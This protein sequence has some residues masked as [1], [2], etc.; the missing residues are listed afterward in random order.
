MTADAPTASAT[1][2]D[3]GAPSR[4][5]VDWKRIR[6]EVRRLQVRIAKATQE[7]RWGKVKVLQRLL[8][9]SYSGKMLAVK[10]VTENRGKN[11]PG[12][13]GEIW[14]TPAAKS[15]GVESLRR[16]GYQPMPLRRVYIPKSNGKKRPLG[17]PTMKDRAMQALWK[18]ALE[19]VAETTADPDSYGFR[20]ARSTA[21]AIGQCFNLLAQAN[22]VEWIL[23]GDIRGCFD[24][25]SHEWLL[26]NIPM[27]WEILRKWLKAGFID[28]NTFFAT[29]AGT[30]QGGIISPILANMTLD[31]LEETLRARFGRGRSGRSSH[32]V[33]VVRYADDFIV[34]GASKEILETEVRPVVERFMSTRGLELSQEKTRIAHIAEGFDF[35]GQNV[36]KYNGKLLIKPSKQNVK[37]FLGKIREVVKR[38]KTAHQRNLILLLNPI[39]RGW[40]QYH[41]HVVAAR[42]FASA[43]HWI[44]CTLWYWSKRRH[45]NKSAQWIMEKYFRTRGSR[46]WV[47]GAK[48]RLPDGIHR[49]VDLCLASDVSIRRHRK[50]KKDAN[51]FD[52]AWDD[53]FEQRNR[54]KVETSRT[55]RRKLSADG[56][57]SK[58]RSPAAVP[59]QY[60]YSR[61]HDLDSHVG[62]PGSDKEPS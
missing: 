13:D 46:K 10:R 33:H 27:D 62:K 34:T 54:Y 15:H 51:P 12:V 25:I 21:D 60:S 19:P 8:T 14:R 59:L 55:D 57:H 39:I 7:G 22:T 18:L 58:G 20:P 42:T 61:G 17:I 16:R 47:F 45:P 29:E 9:R 52:P 24:N 40:A 4:S 32:R 5:E 30:P 26:E 56:G 2:T 11:T 53:Y 31:G 49:W 38:N 37:A 6:Q 50:I 23:E 3:A 1:R 35:L 43:D 28:E 48:V 44:W 41:R 36:R